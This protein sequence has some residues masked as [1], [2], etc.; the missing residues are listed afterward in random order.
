[1]ERVNEQGHPHVCTVSELTPWTFAASTDSFVERA[2]VEFSSKSYQPIS[3]LSRDWNR[4]E[5]MTQDKLVP[6]M[7]KHTN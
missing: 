5:R 1:M 4:E 2:G 6:E 3:C 7:L